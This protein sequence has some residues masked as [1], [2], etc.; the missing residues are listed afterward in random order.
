M[1]IQLQLA[2]EGV[3]N[4]ALVHCLNLAR[5]RKR[6][7][8]AQEQQLLARSWSGERKATEALVNTNQILIVTVS[9][10]NEDYRLDSL[11]RFAAG[12]AALISASRRYHPEL[13]GTFRGHCLLKIREAIEQTLA[14]VAGLRIVRPESGWGHTVAADPHDADCCCTGHGDGLRHCSGGS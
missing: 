13:D 14:E 8:L 5:R 10:T 9:E 4:V 1:E 6:L 3:G 2:V 7:T 12:N 11:D